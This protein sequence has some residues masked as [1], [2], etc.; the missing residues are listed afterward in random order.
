MNG[1]QIN[2][3]LR[4]CKTGNI[5]EAARQLFVAQPAVSKQIAAL[6]KEIGFQLFERTNRGVALT[7]GGERMYAFFSRTA[8]EYEQAYHEAQSAMKEEG[9]TLEIGLLESLGLEQLPKV[10]QTMKQSH[11][12]LN[13]RLIRLDAGTLLQ[14]LA[15][16]KLDVA[17][18]FDHALDHCANVAYVELLLEQ[19]LFIISQDHP[20][21]KRSRLCPRDLSGQIICQTTKPDGIFS[22]T[23]LHHLLHL[24]GIQ[25][26]GY[27]CVDNLA[28]GLEAVEMNHAVGLIDEMVQ[29]LRP[30]RYRTIESGTSQSVV[31][32]SVRNHK[33]PFLESFL[34]ILLQRCKSTSER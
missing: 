34:R 16:E 13:I 20:L 17:I 26:K 5:S 33:N 25:P 22:D 18:T 23:Y 2:Y 27:L 6:E 19:S 32:A 4:L 30:E 21:A 11:P 3:F 10:I 24:L 9:S 8:K 12:N 7:A 1:L 14:R 28:S 15:D 31:A 29:L